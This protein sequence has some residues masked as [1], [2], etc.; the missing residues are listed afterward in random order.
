MA[1]SLN[2][3]LNDSGAFR[4]NSVYGQTN[5]RPVARSRSL[6][7]RSIDYR[8]SLRRG[9]DQLTRANEA[10]CAYFTRPSE[11]FDMMAELNEESQQS[12]TITNI[13]RVRPELRL[14]RRKGALSIA[15][16]RDPKEAPINFRRTPGCEGAQTGQWLHLLRDRRGGDRSRSEMAFA[17]TL[18]ELSSP[19]GLDDQRSDSCLVEMLGKKKWYGSRDDADRRGDSKRSSRQSGRSEQTSRA[20][21]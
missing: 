6:P 20:S 8:Y 14:E 11:S 16:R 21:R 3:S 7:D 12:Q 17:T 19:D 10:W 5:L 9:A 18:R 13:P 1:R 15:M 2:A 4:L